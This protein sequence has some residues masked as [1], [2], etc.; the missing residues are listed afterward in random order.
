MQSEL[1]ERAKTAW[2]SIADEFNQWDAL[3]LD[4]QETYVALTAALSEQ[5]AVGVK[6]LEW[7]TNWG[8]VKAET[9]IGHYYIEARRD[10]GFDLRLEYVWSVWASGSKMAKAAAQADYEQR[11]R[12]ALVD[13]PAVEP[14]AWALMFDGRIIATTFKSAEASYMK[15]TNANC[16]LIPLYASPLREGED[17]AEVLKALK[18]AVEFANKANNYIAG[19]D[20]PASAGWLAVIAKADAALAATRSGSAT[21]AKGGRNDG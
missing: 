20:L 18:E 15:A 7:S 1:T 16:D 6:A 8:I 21:A 9:P 2:N 5:Q 3:G 10:G 13:V 4:E 14:V 17:S 12:S 11:I 19:Q